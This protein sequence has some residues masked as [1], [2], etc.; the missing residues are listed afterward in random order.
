MAAA[1][2]ESAPPAGETPDAATLEGRLAVTLAP[3]SGLTSVSYQILS[4]IGDTLASGVFAIDET[5]PMAS[6]MLTLPLGTGEVIDLQGTT[7]GGA[8]CHGMSAPFNVV[9]NQPVNVNVTLV[10]RTSDDAGVD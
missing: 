6:L 2:A 7:S 4:G 8:P 9:E 10:C 3:G 1:C 5:S